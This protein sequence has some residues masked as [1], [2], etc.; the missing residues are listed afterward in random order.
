MAK[1]TLFF[2]AL[3]IALGLVGY[4][5]SGSQ[6]PTALIPAWFGV[7]LAIFGFL[8]ISPSEG[9]RKLFMHVNV[10]IG[11]L[12]FLGGAVEGIRGYGKPPMLGSS[13]NLIS[14]ETAKLW[15]AALMLIYVLLC[16]RSFISAR[17]QLA[18]GGR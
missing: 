1:V 6:H 2:A 3:L 5:G 7:A 11:L 15:M 9:R 10:T 12:G 18:A 14:A 17:R 4:L 8:A 16:V 13:H